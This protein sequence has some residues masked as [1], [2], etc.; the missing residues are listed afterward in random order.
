MH[1]QLF[2]ISK[3]IKFI[4]PILLAFILTACPS[5]DDC[6]KTITIPQFFVVGN[7]TYSTE[8]TQEVPCDFPEPTEPEVVDIP[9]LENFTYEIISF[10]YIGETDNNTTIL[11][12]EIQL[13]NHNN[14]PVSGLPYF[15]INSSELE[16]STANYVNDAVNPCLSIQS[17][18]SCLFTFDQEY[19]LNGTL[20]PTT[21]EI[22]NVQYIITD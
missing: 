18:S 7:Q 9:F 20:A 10:T 11:Q 12:F 21:F 3:R 1:N 15:T 8:T 22:V 2:L 17:N 16:F 5:D 14:Y 13:N 6:T 19:P 4:F